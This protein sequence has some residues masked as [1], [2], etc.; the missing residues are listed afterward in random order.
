MSLSKLTTSALTL[1][2][3][4]TAAH[5]SAHAAGGAC[6]K[7]FSAAKNW[8]YDSPTVGSGNKQFSIGVGAGASFSGECDKLVG[9][10]YVA[11][12]ARA[13]S[14]GGNAL[15][16]HLTATVKNSGRQSLSASFFAFG[17]QLTDPVEL[18]DSAVPLKHTW[19]DSWTLPTSAATRGSWSGSVTVPGTSTSLG[20]A[21]NYNLVADL[22]GIANYDV[23]PT[24]LYVGFWGQANVSAS[25][26]VTGSIST[27]KLRVSAAGSSS[28][29]A[30]RG[31]AQAYIN[32]TETTLIQNAPLF[33]APDTSTVGIKNAWR[34]RALAEYKIDD[35]IHGKLVARVTGTYDS[36]PNDNVPGLSVDHSF[37]VYELT[38]GLPSSVFSAK[39]WKHDKT[40]YKPF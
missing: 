6:P 28:F 40:Y 18:A 4:V 12:R 39:N 2:L 1:L 16:A 13:F 29:V 31:M 32:L 30:F 34:L 36:N 21:V 25:T 8:S 33:A 9:D 10:T 37:T 5:S 27:S 11:I 19:I 38:S 3:G 15:E 20:Y 26:N 7:A 23:K 17:Y 35:A 22:L 24:G 14:L